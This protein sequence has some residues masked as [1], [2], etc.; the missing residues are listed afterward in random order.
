MAEWSARVS[1]ALASAR[2]NAV[3]LAELNAALGPAMGDA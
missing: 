2:E 3:S 1:G